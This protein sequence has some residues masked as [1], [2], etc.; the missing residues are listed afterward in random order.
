MYVLPGRVIKVVERK[1]K[2]YKI[3]GTSHARKPHFSFPKGSVG[4]VGKVM[5]FSAPN[6]KLVSLDDFTE[7]AAWAGDYD[8]A[9]TF[10]EAIVLMKRVENGMVM[11]HYA[12]EQTPD[13]EFNEYSKT[14]RMIIARIQRDLKKLEGVAREMER[15]VAS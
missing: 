13:N 6:T 7:P 5:I 2:T 9:M 11:V 8:G 1:G 10:D 14:A 12:E 15:I 4:P 3:R